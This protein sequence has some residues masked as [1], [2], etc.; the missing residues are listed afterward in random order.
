M[1]KIKSSALPI[2]I[3][4]AFASL[5]SADDK[6]VSAPPS[7]GIVNDYLR[8]Q[9]PG[10]QAWDLGGQVRARLEHK[11]YF[12]APG[13]VDFARFGDDDNTY[14]LLREKV[15]L[16]YTPCPWFTT[17]L[18]GRDSSSQNDDRHPNVD[19]DL[20]DLHQGYIRIGDA[21]EFPVSL[22]L[23]RQELSYGDE[24]LIGPSDWGN[25]PR[26]FDAAKVRY[27]NS[28]FWVDAFFGRPVVPRQSKLNLSNE[29][30][31]FWGL[32]GSTKT[33]LPKHE[34]QVYFLGRN[35][36]TSSPTFINDSLATLPS[37]RDIYTLGARLKSLP[38]SFGNW[39][40]ELEGAYQF[41][42]FKSTST[43]ASLDQNAFAAHAAGGYTFA[44][45]PTKPRVGLEYNYASGDSD[46]TDGEHGTF[47]NLFPTN[48][49]FYGYMDFVSWQNI[50]D[51]RA[52]A[53]LKPLPPLL[54]TADVHGF[55][56][57]DANDYFY[58]V[59]GAPRK[60]GGYGINP[61]AGDYVGSEI[62]FVATYTIK[63]YAIAQAGY[64]HFFVGEYVKNSLSATG[65]S[66]D[67]DWIYGQ[68]VFNF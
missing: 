46:P 30:D 52:T 58:T 49:K 17:F 67:A 13:V 10:F 48:H 54:L 63:P 53:S 11:E 1:T 56:L 55:W 24:R 59:G 26:A 21:S 3:L 20:F 12:A 29:H 61:G 42:R 15:H 37:P 65:G 66:H 14:F 22:K 9:S 18:E 28:D 32:Y 68:L 27:E 7:A 60:T 39:D 51:L 43:S 31:N 8:E 36:D 34:T 38:A 57:A 35:T 45:A 23:G 40:Y 4:A 2:A 19:A 33:L 25:I 50:H 47:D 5:A 64:G 44:E 6:K 62:D 16:G 41:G